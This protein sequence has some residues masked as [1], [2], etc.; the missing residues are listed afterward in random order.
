MIFSLSNEQE[1]LLAL[2]ELWSLACALESR[3]LAL[4]DASIAAE[5]SCRLQRSA[6]LWVDEQK[7][8]ADAM[9][10]SIGL[11]VFTAPLCNGFNIIDLELIGDA[12]RCQSVFREHPEEVILD[13]QSV[14]RAGTRT[15]LEELHARDSG[16][17]FANSG[18]VLRRGSGH[19]GLRKGYG[20]GLLWSECM[21]CTSKYV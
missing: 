10:D 20:S 14:D 15:V 21:L 3:L 6:Q 4:L 2:A 17:S 9:T 16:L 7:C 8:T 1:I 5:E 18:D 19:E 13:L 11:G 12:Q